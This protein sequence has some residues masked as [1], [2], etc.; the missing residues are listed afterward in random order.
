MYDLPSDP[1][2]DAA[3]TARSALDPLRQVSA[4]VVRWS[5][6]ASAP[7]WDELAV[8]EPLELRLPDAPDGTP[9]ASI[10]AIMRTPGHDGEL[11]A[12]FLFGEGLIRDTS[13]LAGFAPGSD[14]DGLP[15]ANALV[16][17][18]A[19]GVD[20]ARRLREAGYS[21]QFAVNASCGVC[22]K[23]SVAA[24]C[25][26]LPPLPDGALRLDPAILYTLPDRLRAEQ[27]VF[28]HTGGLHAAGLFDAAGTLLALREDVGRHNAVDKLVGR[29]LLDGALPL[30]GR[31]LLVSG[32]LSFEIV[33]K[34][35][36]AGIPLVAAVSAPSSLAVDLAQTGNIT[37]AGFLRGPGVNVYTHPWR[38]ESRTRP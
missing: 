10:A 19:P 33:L 23:N 27:R 30:A 5:G 15:D 25:A 22:G 7:A 29:A 13:E 34:A 6:G 1:D 4:G 14:T 26:A 9:G 12:G 3:L 17:R 2:P 20:L 8:E 21:R 35:L 24:A 11:A 28:A 16:V 32:R 37:L 18:P 31:V 38:I 36:A